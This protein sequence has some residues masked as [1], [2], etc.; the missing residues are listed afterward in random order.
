[1]NVRELLDHPRPRAPDLDR[2]GTWLGTDRPLLFRDALKGRVVLLDFWT[3]GCINCLHAQPVL[4]ALE[5]RFAGAPFQVVGI[6]SGKFDAEKE[7]PAVAEA[8]AR[9]GIEHPVATDSDFVLWDQYAIHGWPTLILVDARGYVV[10]AVRGEPELATL[11]GL[12]QATLDDAVRRGV[13]AAGPPVFR[14]PAATD[15]GPLSFPGKVLALGDGRIAVS[16]TGHHRILLLDGSGR[17]HR[18]IGSGLEGFSDGP[19]ET[20]SFRRPQGLVEHDG[21]LYVADTENHAIRRLDL[22]SGAVST[23]AGTGQ[24]GEGALHPAPDARTVALRSPWD[25]CAIGDTLWIA[26][27]GAHQLWRLEVRTGALQPGAGNGREGLDDGALAE[28]TF[29]QPSGLAT[30]GRVLYVADSEASAIRKV[31]PAAGKV[32]TLVGKGLFEFGDRDGPFARA[33]LQ[34]P[35]GLALVGETLYVADTFNGKVRRLMLASGQVSTVTPSRSLAQPGGLTWAGG[36]LLLADTD[37][38]RLVTVNPQNGSVGALILAG[39]APPVLQGLS[40]RPVLA[41]RALP[42]QHLADAA[43]ASGRAS[44]VLEVRLP[45]GYTFTHGAPQRAEVSVDGAQLRPASP[46]S[47]EAKGDSLTITTP[48]E[49]SPGT[50]TVVHTVALFYCKG[51][52]ASVCLVDRR[53]LAARLTLSPAGPASAIVQY[54]PTPPA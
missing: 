36:K 20:A 45:A 42:L 2:A 33:Q 29:A 30:D 10:T 14:R 5:H 49:G 46:P 32:W 40:E 12:V 22:T 23:V 3:S 47:I 28:A 6:H 51:G 26:M 8:M 31:D 39:V 4:K 7:V 37:H 21:A 53:R 15:S 38:H 44:L 1:M 16:D 34:H 17:L 48:L 11:T 50:A 18:A 43:I 35:L 9:H 41:S 25:L 52:N 19:P 27:A 54:R 24:K 13:A